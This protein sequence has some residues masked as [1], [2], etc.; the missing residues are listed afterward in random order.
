[1]HTFSIKACF[2]ER[3]SG[4]SV[5]AVDPAP[6]SS[7]DHPLERGVRGRGCGGVD[8]ERGR[9]G[10][11]TGVESLVPGFPNRGLGAGKFPTAEAEGEKKRLS[12]LQWK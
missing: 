6:K 10:H 11:Q 12:L 5:I 1:M 2:K 3:A 9:D 8:G 4:R 7:P